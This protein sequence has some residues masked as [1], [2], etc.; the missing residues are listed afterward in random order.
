M[1]KFIRSL[2]IVAAIALGVS[3]VATD[4]HATALAA[5]RLTASKNQ[6]AIKRYLMTDSIT[7]YAGSL[8]MIVDAG[9]VEAAAATA[10][11]QGVAG[12]ALETKTSGTAD[13]YIQVQEGWFLFA[14]D[15]LEQGDVGLPVYADDDQTVDETASTNAPCA[16]V[17]MEYVSASSGWVHVALTYTARWASSAD[18]ITFTGDI[19]ASGGAGALTFSGSAASIVVDDADTTALV[20]GSSGDLSILTVDTGEAAEGVIVT[21]YTTSSGDITAQGG[22]G[23]VTFSDSASSIV[24]PNN[25]ASAL[26]IGGSGLTTLIRLDTTTSTQNVLFGGGTAHS[27]VSITGATTLDA[28]DCGKPLFVTAGIDTAAITLPALA[29]V[30][31]GCVY[32]FMYVGADAGALLDISPNAADGIEGG[33]TLAAS[34]VYFSGADDGDVGLTKATILT[35]DTITLTSG[36]ADDWYATAIQGICAGN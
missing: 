7:I 18:P 25:D 2:A 1:T 5:A 13:M 17:L 12:V 29:T 14:G 35:G 24:V 32:K 36:D 6:G 27:A 15:T 3:A 21:G 28:S 31:A 19:T 8:V 11:N 22:A 16:G 9:T 26:D 10:S 23:A 30:P 34:V 33:C 20:I 4:A